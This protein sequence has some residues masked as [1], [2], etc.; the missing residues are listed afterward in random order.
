MFGRA[1][2]SV[3]ST[4]DG[5]A[6]VAV[7]DFNGDGMLDLA[8]VQA[9]RNSVAI[10]LGKVDGTLA[11]A[12]YYETGSQPV[13][14]AGGDFNGDGRQDLVIANQNCGSASYC[15]TKGSI[16]ILLGNGDGTFQQHTEFAPGTQPGSIAVGDL[17]GDGKLDLALSN[18]ALNSVLLFL[19]NG[20]GTFQAPVPYSIPAAAAWVVAGDFNGDGRLDLAVADS[21]NTVSIFLGRGDGTFQRGGDVLV[22]FD[23][24]ALIVRDF[25]GDGVADL[26]VTYQQENAVSVLLGNGDGTFQPR[27][28]YPTGIYPTA[29]AVG[30]FNGDGRLDLAVANDADQTFSVLL[31]NGDGTLQAAV[32]YL[33][34]GGPVALAVAD[35]NRDGKPDLAAVMS[36]LGVVSV[37]TGRGDGTFPGPQAY[38]S[39]Q[40]SWAIAAGDFDGDGQLDLVTTNLGDNSISVFLGGGD[41]IFQMGG[42]SGAGPVPVAAGVGDFNRDGKLDLAVV[43]Q[44]CTSLPCSPGSVSIFL[45]NGD[46]TFQPRSDYAA[47]NIPVGVAVADFNGDGIPDLAVV[48]NGFG[49]SNSVSILLG[50]GDGTFRSGGALLTGTGPFQAV[51]ADFEGNGA[52]DLAAAFNGGISIIPGGGNGTFGTRS[53][54]AIPN[55]A[56]AIAAG[57]FN[58]DGKPDLAV[59]TTDSVVVLL[60]K[61]DGT[62]QSGLSYYLASSANQESTLVGD[63]NADGKLD[64]LVGKSGNAV[65]ILLGNGDGTFL[66]SVDIPAG[67]AVHGWVT[68][69]FNGDGGLDLAVASF[70]SNAAFVTLNTPVVGLYPAGLKFGVQGVGASS[71]PLAVTV[72]NPSGAPLHIATV[73][74]SGAFSLTNGCPLTLAPG[75]SC[76]LSVV[77]TPTAAGDSGG[78][79]TISDNAP[80]SPHYVTLQGTG[81]GGPTAYASPSS[82]TFDSQD[83]RTASAAKTVTLAN[84]GSV[85]LSVSRIAASGD[86][87]ATDTCV[88]SLAAGAECTILVTFT[89][90]AAGT[91]TG[92]LTITDNAAAGS[93]TVALTGTGVANPAASLSASSLAFGNQRVHTTSS[94]QIVSLINPGNTPLEI[95]S[96]VVTGD[97]AVTHN[98]PASLGAAASCTI[99]VSFTPGATGIL[100]GSLSVTDNAAGSPQSIALTGRGT[101]PQVSLSA[102]SLSFS[103]Q[104]V[105]SASSTQSLTLSNTGDAA[106]AISGVAV[107]GSDSKDFALQSGCGGSLNPGASCAVSLT[108]TPASAGSRIATLLITTNAAGSPHAVLLTGT[109]KD[110]S[111]SVSAGSASALTV[112]PGQQ[113][114]FHMTLAPGGMKDTVDFSCA[115]APSGSTC[116]VSPATVPLDG[117]TPVEVTVSVQTTAPSAALFRTPQIPGGVGDHGELLMTVAMLLALLVMAGSVGQTFRRRTAWGLA[118][119]LLATVLL[120]G[121]G[122]G[123]QVGSGRSLS[124]PGTP[125]GAY[126]LTITAVS[127]EVSHSTTL[128]L[129]VQK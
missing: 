15:G 88:P 25:N 5:P 114:V 106:L 64:L 28:D 59:T 51:A 93:R 123:D 11:P 37:V 55:G 66:P 18:G 96:I 35:F 19:G 99:S 6:S 81:I 104:V 27:L 52:M 91:R 128:R 94:P 14:V 49:F 77:F 57:D 69:D 124:Q 38:G 10:L 2:F 45:G 56:L 120:P 32:D 87:A 121:C 110:F 31:G 34:P 20:D 30:D 54:Y 17:N 95:S 46:G 23:P 53:D 61:G 47:G 4:G 29:L 68:G 13:A 78:V 112:S 102:S 62:F 74:A 125:V 86:F 44:T 76:A 8:I 116:Q 73:T 92:T 90:T 82:L 119:L 3:G 109:G 36:P 101:V 98:C 89:P 117:V 115:G 129:S 84:Q 33:L 1:S 100:V 60:G 67:M 107:T 40:G 85:P 58:R 105:G 103:S 113:A 12:T 122:G 7:G 126:T 75:T 21:G 118:T 70:G 9:S 50:R 127:R 71:A 83:V 65:S 43:N 22:L 24:N 42:T 26:A 108:F 80:G 79:L 41:G 16:S 111:L 72:S 48:N 63:F 39:S 97:F